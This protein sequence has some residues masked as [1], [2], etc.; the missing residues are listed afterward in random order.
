MNAIFKRRSVRKFSEEDIKEEDITT[1][2]QAA[3]RAPSAGNEQPWEFII[4]KNPKALSQITEFHPYATML[5]H[6][7]CAI[8]VCGDI[9]RQKFDYDFWVQ[10]CSAATQNIL[11]EATYLGLGSVWLGVHPIKERVIGLQKLLSLPKEIIPLNIIA[12]G[13][14]ETTPST[15]DTY[16]PTHIHHEKW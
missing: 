9:R 16:D 6:T 3:M 12:L 7:K 2:L 1:L 10:D 4:I 15:I 8:V 11:I 13:Y 14:P 5:H